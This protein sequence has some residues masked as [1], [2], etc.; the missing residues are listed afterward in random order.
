MQISVDELKTWFAVIQSFITILSIIIVG[1]WSFY[2]FVLGRSFAP[3][4]QIEYTLKK[5]IQIEDTKIAILNIVAENIGKSHVNK[6]NC[7]ISITPL[8]FLQSELRD[9]VKINS[10]EYHGNTKT[11]PIFRDHVALE[12]NEKATEDIIFVVGDALMLRLQATF[13]SR[14]KCWISSAIVELEKEI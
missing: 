4:I 6:K 11:Y 12:P 10:Q 2:N 9:F 1:I 14:S 8:T 5:I 3:N 7:Y 13:M